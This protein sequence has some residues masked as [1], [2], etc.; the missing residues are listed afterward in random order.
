M[1]NP[2]SI[3]VN[4][5]N[6]HFK[7]EKGELFSVLKDINFSV[8]RGETLALIGRNGSGKTTLLKII[9]EIL[10]PTSGK[11][12]IVGNTAALIDIDGLFERD[13]TGREN[14]IHFLKMNGWTSKAIFSI[15]EEI[16][17]FS[18]LDAFF[19]RTMKTYS[20][21]MQSRLVLSTAL[22]LKADLFLI[23]EVFFAGDMRFINQLE[24]RKNELC[25]QGVSF[26]IATHNPI[27]VNAFANECIWIESAEIQQLGSPEIVL[28]DYEKFMTNEL[29]H[30]KKNTLISSQYTQN[31]VQEKEIDFVKCIQLEQPN[32][33]T[34]S[35]S[36]GFSLNIAFQTNDP[37][38]KIYPGVHILDTNRK[39]IC[40]STALN[41]RELFTVS[42]E[43]N[44]RYV[45][46]F[47]KETL[48]QGH[49]LIE[50]FFLSA[51]YTDIPHL[52]EVYRC[53]EQFP[54]IVHADSQIVFGED[55]PNFPLNLKASWK[56]D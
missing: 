9:A 37:T 42:S 49:Y 18:G 1:Q 53:P 12:K 2:F 17:T 16:K 55:D 46:D 56:R 34:F 52:H 5:I 38:L 27:E 40:I 8:K 11:I 39:I 35:Y 47:P 31:K 3:E 54:L 10:K 43:T 4:N 14:V 25:K 19:E 32:K 44:H 15:I 13:L 21:G 22:Y 41:T 23:D 51:P 48:V 28:K 36:N 26:I 24:K 6:K 29:S 50:L 30:S 20:K 7:S 33:E 45:L